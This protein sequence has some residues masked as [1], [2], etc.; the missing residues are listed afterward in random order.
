MAQRSGVSSW[1]TK[2]PSAVVLGAISTLDN[3]PFHP[4]Q[5][6]RQNTQWFKDKSQSLYLSILANVC[7]L[8]FIGYK[9]SSAKLACRRAEFSYPQNKK[10]AKLLK[11]NLFSLTNTKS[12]WSNSSRPRSESDLKS[13]NMMD[14]L[15]FFFFLPFKRRHIFYVGYAYFSKNYVYMFLFISTSGC[16]QR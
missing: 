4:K 7:I 6:N 1:H 11:R 8:I 5:T 3:H 13:P 15:V 16:A 12:T 9:L 2:V 10:S 14:F